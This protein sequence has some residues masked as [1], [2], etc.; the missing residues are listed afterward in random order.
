[1]TNKTMNIAK[2][3]LAINIRAQIATTKKKLAAAYEKLDALNVDLRD[4]LKI[5]EE[6]GIDLDEGQRELPF[7]NESDADF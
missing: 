3:R 1:M 7:N 2:E 4:L 6:Q 5:S